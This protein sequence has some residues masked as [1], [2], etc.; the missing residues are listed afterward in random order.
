ML[1]GTQLF[2]AY[3]ILTGGDRNIDFFLRDERL[4][5]LVH[6]PWKTEGTVE[7]NIHTRG[8]YEVCFD[9]SY[10]RFAAKL[11]YFYMSA[12]VPEHW[13]GYVKEIE[14]VYRTV[15]NFSVS[16]ENLQQNIKNAVIHQS[17]SRM[18][19]MLDYYTIM[20]NNKYVQYWSILQCIIIISTS[21]LQVFFVRRLFHSTNVTPTMKPRA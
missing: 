12:F 17:S 4:D 13:D 6:K 3:E 8:I 20:G 10:S 15:A 21:C 16:L 2:I 1:N 11:V 7:E 14:D 18:Y 5:I 19:V 9:N